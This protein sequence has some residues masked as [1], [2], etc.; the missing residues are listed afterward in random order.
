[1]NAE[2]P[3]VADAMF[4]ELYSELHRLA[5]RELYRGGR[6]AAGLGVTTVLHEAYLKISGA[7]GPF[8]S[9]MHTSWDMR[10]A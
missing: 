9:I 2:K 6:P 8:S 7:E 10:P 4:D 3:V 5:R 1:M